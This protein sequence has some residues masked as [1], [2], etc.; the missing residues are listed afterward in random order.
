MTLFTFFLLNLQGFLLQGKN[1]TLLPPYL[2]AC[3]LLGQADL[4][5]Y[6]PIPTYGVPSL[7]LVSL[8]TSYSTL[9][10]SIKTDCN[11]LRAVAGILKGG[12]IF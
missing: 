8:P 4:L 5:A 7:N 11:Y 10:L 6:Y 1:Q 2:K 3:L 12:D 9:V